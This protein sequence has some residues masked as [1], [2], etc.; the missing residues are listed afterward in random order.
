M[1]VTARL[2]PLLLPLSALALSGCATFRGGPENIFD[3]TALVKKAR[4]YEV[5]AVD[6]AIE[7]LD[8]D[9]MG[10]KR[11]RNKVVRSYMTAIDAQYND[12]RSSVGIEGRGGALAFDILTL[13]LATAGSLSTG[14]APELAAAA[15]AATG[16]RAAIDKNLVGEKTIPALFAAMEAERF[17]MRATIFERMQEEYADYPMEAVWNDLQSYRVAGTMDEAISQVTDQAAND[18]AEARAAYNRSLGISCD[19]K[20]DVLE[21]AQK[22]G[23]MAR[24]ARIAAESGADAQAKANGRLKLVNIANAFN[25]P[26]KPADTPEEIWE[27]IATVLELDYCD[28]DG[29]RR[30]IDQIN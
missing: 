27:S 19:A 8:G 5:S 3:T 1:N 16:T 26:T 20:Q 12:F 30:R 13:G 24:D 15:G 6:D 17:R 10:Q 14:A 7:T 18:R 29:L 11:Y 4:T 2:G 22:V 23:D 28:A 21:V 25:V 9:P